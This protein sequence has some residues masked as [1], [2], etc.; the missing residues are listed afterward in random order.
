M[1]WIWDF[2]HDFEG[3][4]RVVKISTLLMHLVHALPVPIMG[5]ELETIF[6]AFRIIMD[7]INISVVP[8]VKGAQVRL[9]C[10]G[11]DVEVMWIL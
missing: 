9:T 2:P 10:L 1:N 8:W 5:L 3:A 11:R 4:M 7:M 6:G